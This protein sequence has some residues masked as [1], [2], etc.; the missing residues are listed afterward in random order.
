[1]N[2]IEHHIDVQ[3]CIIKLNRPKVFNSFNKA[4]ALELQGILDDC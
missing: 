3:V 1:M 2:Y 4:M